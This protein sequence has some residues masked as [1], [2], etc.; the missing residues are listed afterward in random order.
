MFR[1]IGLI[2]YKSEFNH[3]HVRQLL[4][5]FVSENKACFQKYSRLSIEEH[6]GRMRYNRCWGTAIEILAIASLL[7]IPVYTYSPAGSHNK[8]YRWI[9][10][11]PLPESSLHFPTDESYPKGADE[12]NHL[13]LVHTGAYHYDCVVWE[14]GVYSQEEPTLTQ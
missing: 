8:V 12:L 6:I 11:N 1:A 10:Y 5:N 2:V 14:D 3:Q 4:V 13:E 7:Q 9:Q